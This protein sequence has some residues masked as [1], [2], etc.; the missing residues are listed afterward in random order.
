METIILKGQSSWEDPTNRE[1]KEIQHLPKS[2]SPHHRL[3]SPEPSVILDVESGTDTE[4]ES[5]IGDSSEPGYESGEYEN[6]ANWELEML[7]AQM[8]KK[9]SASLDYSA[10]KPPIRRRILRGGSADTHGHKFD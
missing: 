6:N 2:I 10:S 7:A 5:D 4:C 1:T 8:R 3:Q 9:R